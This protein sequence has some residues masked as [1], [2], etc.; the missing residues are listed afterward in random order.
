VSDEDTSHPEAAPR[1]PGA[2]SDAATPLAWY[3]RRGTLVAGVVVA[4]LAVTII[5]DLPA[6]DNRASDIAAA[7][8]IVSQINTD[9]SPC[10]NAS[11][12][13]FQLY[14]FKVAGTLNSYE[15][16]NEQQIISQDVVACSLANEQVF[17]LSDINVPLTSSGKLLAAA[18]SWATLWATSDALDAMNAIQ[19]L[20][21]APADA[22]QLA[23][24]GTQWRL[25]V[26]HR[27]DADSAVAAAA[28]LL[29]TSLP[30]L[31]LPAI[32]RPLTIAPT[33]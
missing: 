32:P 8:T 25:L 1:F 19:R 2:P 6:P 27:T 14:S 12:E 23:I 4:I 5:T 26:A 13:A 7:K 31:G 10:T 18:L 3:R 22:T 30:S 17:E 24:L 21:L 11:S 9:L 28:T 15:N 16:A 20:M 33:S 29:S